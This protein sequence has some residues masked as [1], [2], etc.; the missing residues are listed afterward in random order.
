MPLGKKISRI[1]KSQY[2]KGLQCPKALWIYRNRPDLAPEIP[3]SKQHIFDQGHEVGIL[4]QQYFAGGVEVTEKYYEID[5][6]ITSTED[7]IRNG[8]GN[9]YEAT[10]CSPDGAYSR[11]DI[12]K[13]ASMP[14]QWDLIEVKQSTGVK[15]YHLDD[16]ALQR[17]AFKNAGYNVKN[18]YLMHINGSYVRFGPLNLQ[19]LF[20]LEDCTKLL[21][22]VKNGPTFRRKT[23]PPSRNID[24]SDLI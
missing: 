4:A 14:D 18:S 13:E 24:T 11:I 19:E 22:P 3:A 9:I 21:L 1:S 10:A 8:A 5:K 6:A 16:I 12:L 23:D 17:Y 20:T 15:D 7:H 2:L